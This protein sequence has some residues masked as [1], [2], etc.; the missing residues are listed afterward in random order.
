MSMEITEVIIH[1]T[2]DVLVKACATII[3][4]NCFLVREIRVIRGTGGL[5]V[6]FPVN[7][8]KDGSHRL[9]ALPANAKTRSMIERAVLTEYEKVV[10]RDPVST[11]QNKY[12]ATVATDSAVR[13]L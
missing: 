1:P 4:D 2:N 13:S 8:E 6:S 5:F 11:R 7:T 10:G 3:F 12:S 9:I